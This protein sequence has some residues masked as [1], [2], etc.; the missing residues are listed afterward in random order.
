MMPRFIPGTALTDVTLTD[1]V[2]VTLSDTVSGGYKRWTFS[3][4]MDKMA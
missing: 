1:S 4:S 3:D 2:T